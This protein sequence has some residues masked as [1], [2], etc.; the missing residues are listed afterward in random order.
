MRWTLVLISGEE[1]VGN[2]AML[3]KARP[4]MQACATGLIFGRKVWHRQ[5]RLRDI[6]AKLPECVRRSGENR[7]AVDRRHLRWRGRRPHL[8]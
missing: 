5:Q 1:K 7:E 8:C 4:S 2:E 6:L 3:E